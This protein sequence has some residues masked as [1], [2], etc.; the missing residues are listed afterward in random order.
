VSGVTDGIFEPLSSG[1]GA[2]A[3]I[4]AADFPLE[5]PTVGSAG[6]LL[7]AASLLLVALRVLRHRG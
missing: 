2:L 6:L 7:L 3:L 1:F 5:I 4:P